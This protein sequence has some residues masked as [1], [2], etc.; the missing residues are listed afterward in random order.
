MKTYNKEY[1]SKHR[2]ES[3]ISCKQWRE[4][5]TQERSDYLREWRENNFSYNLDWRK[6]HREE[7]RKIARESERRRRARKRNAIVEQIDEDKIY[8]RDCNKCVYCGSVNNLT[9]DHIIPIAKNGNHTENNLVIACQSCNSSKQDKPLEKWLMT[10]FGIV[11]ENKLATIR[12]INR[13]YS[14]T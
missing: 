7:N 3:S 12:K 14:L 11:G 2:E 13:Y 5:H 6:S 10:K 1:Y 4:N 9:L 8:K